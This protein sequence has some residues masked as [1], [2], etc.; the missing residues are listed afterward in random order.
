M[1]EDP[2]AQNAQDPA[3]QPVAYDA[4]GRPLY[5][6]P[7]QPQPSV[8]H[9]ARPLDPE[10]PTISPE[11]HRL[12]E[13]SNRLYP[14]LNL[15][16]GEYIISAV[17]RHPV[18]LVIPLVVGTLLIAFILAIFFNY[19]IFVEA[20]AVHGALTEAS[21]IAVPVWIFVGLVALSMSITYYVYK[22]N[23]F[24]LTNES[25]IQEIQ[26][27]LFSR[28]EQTVSLANI[29]D[30][31]FTQRGISQQI[32]NYGNIRLSTEGDETT[33]QFSYVAN[34]KEHIARLNNA[35]EAFKNGRPVDGE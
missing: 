23:R 32:L 7:Y 20:F 24:F 12:H 28:Q 4:Q 9:I 2:Q 18:G 34:P 8:V 17:H 1:N 16:E 19:D 22:R 15:S 6:H 13:R 31:S 25:V 33:Y 5:A 35:I 3:A 11:I 30:A 10:K 26:T 27:S 21:S 14:T 29:E